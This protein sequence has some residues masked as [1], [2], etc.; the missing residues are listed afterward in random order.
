MKLGIIGGTGVSSIFGEEDNLKVQSRRLF[1]RDYLVGEIENHEVVF[2]QR[3][4]KGSAPHLI[5]HLWNLRVMR[6]EEVDQILALT[7]CGSLKPTAPPGTFAVP[8]DYVDLT[9]YNKSSIS[10]QR[11]PVPHPPFGNGRDK[12]WQALLAYEEQADQ[13]IILEPAGV[14]VS[15]RGPRFATKA[16]STFYAQQG[17]SFINMTTA[18]EA[19]VALELE[20][21]YSILAVVTDFDSGCPGVH[22]PATYELI[23]ERFA[24]ASQRL[25]SIIPM[26]L[27]FADCD[28]DDTRN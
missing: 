21:P 14:I 23:K 8:H 5:D 27:G 4:A 3:H 10:S 28:E 1:D 9:H 6:H 11:H 17:W 7:A 26:F 24:L 20:I 12:M 13:E 22:E 2:L 18:P 16:E 15:I 25:K 19:S